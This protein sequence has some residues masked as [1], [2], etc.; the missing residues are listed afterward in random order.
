M[1]RLMRRTSAMLAIVAGVLLAAM[2]IWLEIYFWRLGHWRFNS[3][4]LKTD[5]AALALLAGGILSLRG[6]GQYLPAAWSWLLAL[7]VPIFGSA[8]PAIPMLP[9]HHD[10]QFQEIMRKGIKS[11]EAFTRNLNLAFALVALLG[12]VLSLYGGGRR[13]PAP[14]I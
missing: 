7:H 2:M 10:P 14:T 4:D 1:V 9:G 11:A 6:H 3:F 8:P 5:I 12:L 13:S